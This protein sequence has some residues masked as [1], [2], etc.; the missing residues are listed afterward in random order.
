[1]SPRRLRLGR[2]VQHEDADW[3]MRW[4]W[5]D[6]AED[7]QDIHTPL[8]EPTATLNARWERYLKAEQEDQLED[9]LALRRT[10]SRALADNEMARR[11]RTHQPGQR[12]PKEAA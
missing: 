11:V 8:Y 5:Q 4:Y 2:I 6:Q 9:D 10:V 12:D 1:M 7:T 3:H